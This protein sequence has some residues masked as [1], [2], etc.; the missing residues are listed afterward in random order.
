MGR[1]VVVIGAGQAGQSLA[2]RL[3]DLGHSGPITLIGAETEI[4]YQR[5]PLSKK[6][7]LGEM[8]VERLHLKPRSFYAERAITLVTGEAVTAIDRAAREVVTAT[9]R[10]GYDVVALTTGATPR[11]L[12]D[13]IGGGLGGVHTLRTLGDVDAL[14]PAIVEGR[15]ALIVGGGYIGLEAAA[16]AAQKGLKVTLIEA[17][18]RILGRVAAPETAD[19]F[20]RLHRSNG[21]DIRE[22]TA[23]A[24]L[25][26]EAGQVAHAVLADG[27]T[28]AVDVV[29]VG[30]GV[31]P[32]TGL[33][34]AT[35]LALDNGIAVDGLCR[36]SDPAIFAAGDCAS[37]PWRGGR[38]RLESVQNAI[39]MA[40]HAAGAI[41]GAT[42]PYVPVPWFWSDQYAA[43]LQ[44][45]GLNLGYTRIV[46]RP[47]ER[48]GAESVWY[49]E[50]AR[51]LAVDAMNDPKAYMQGKRW[52]EAGVSPSPDAIAD[53]GRDLRSLAP[54]R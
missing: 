21:V 18:P 9:R 25:E 38:V 43:R 5:P 32:A 23:L 27:A 6:Y 11:R 34:A 42:A 40:E 36:T 35:G 48:A 7:L 44:I 16:V 8:T 26:G 39:D 4:P 19:F 1:R 13:A 50:G 54:A 51:F 30:I 28:L 12:P 15:R 46:R 45:A 49:F 53:G 52:L 47:G 3:R 37:F 10:I 33:A 31:D 2:A 22:D 20:R 24:R 29:V 17:A 41:N 14:R